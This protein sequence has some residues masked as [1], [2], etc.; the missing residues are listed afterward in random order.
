VKW[1]QE[2]LDI[3]KKIIE[4]GKAMGATDKQIEAAVS[5]GIVESRLRNLGDLGARNDHQ[6]HGVF[7]Q[8]PFP[9]WGTLAQTMNIDHAARAFFEHA[10]R[11]DKP[12]L[13]AGE[14]AA[15]VQRPAKQYR[16]RYEQ[17]LGEAQQLIAQLNQTGEASVGLSASL[18]VGRDAVTNYTRTL[19]DAEAAFR[20]RY[21]SSGFTPQT[22]GAQDG[23]SFRP[24]SL[25]LPDGGHRFQDM[26]ALLPQVDTSM[27]NLR[28]H[29]DEE[30]HSFERMGESGTAAADTLEAAADRIA[31]KYTGLHGE[32]LKMGLTERNLGSIFEQSFSSAFGHIEQGFKQTTLG[33]VLSFVQAIQ[34]MEAAYL[35]SKLSGFLFGADKPDGTR[36]RGLFGRA[37]RFIPF[38]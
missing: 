7:Q 11:M 36:S 16:G 26:I 15:R 22:T 21:R 35:A 29:T 2:Q 30:A 13:S 19:T 10:A 37:V 9:E 1:T 3:A 23:G 31:K 18:N 34:Q 20:D 5:T 32:L 6:S 38:R 28:R 12:E 17:H 8:Q 25:A 24:G 14:L 27:I 33:F 4:T